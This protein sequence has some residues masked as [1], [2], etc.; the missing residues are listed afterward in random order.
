M[1]EISMNGREL[2]LG[3]LRRPV[4]LPQLQCVK[5]KAKKLPKG[6]FLLLYT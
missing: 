4:G 5:A 1:H 3:T 2:N 6:V